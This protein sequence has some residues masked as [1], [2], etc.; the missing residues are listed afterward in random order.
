[1]R[2]FLLLLSLTLIVFFSKVIAQDPVTSAPAP[3]VTTFV[4]LTPEMSASSVSS[5]FSAL[6]TSAPQQPGDGPS[7]GDAG[8]SA[9]AGDSDAGASGS[10][11]GSITVSRGGIIA[12]VVCVSFVVIFGSK[13]N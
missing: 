5:Y 10:D 13:L 6:A 3:A 8:S 7:A 1:M 9:G 2:T 4:S 11:S 12:I